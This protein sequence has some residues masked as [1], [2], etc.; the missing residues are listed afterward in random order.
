MKKTFDKKI[1][2]NSYKSAPRNVAFGG[3]N[4][5]KIQSSKKFGKTEKCKKEGKR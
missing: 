3:K 2:Y 1:G 5:F 4:L